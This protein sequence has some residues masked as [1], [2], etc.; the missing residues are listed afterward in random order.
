MDALTIRADGTFLLEGQFLG[1]QPRKSSPYGYL[2][3]TTSGCDRTLKLAKS[4]RLMLFRELTPGDWVRVLGTQKIDSKTGTLEWKAREVLKLSPGSQRLA[5]ETL[6]PS[7]DSQTPDPQTPDSQILFPGNISTASTSNPKKSP[8]AKVL[9]CQK[10][11]CR[12]RGSGAICQAFAHTLEQLDQTD[13]VTLKSTG[14][15]DRCKAGPNV[16]ILPDKARYTHVTPAMVP[17]LI[18]HHLSPVPS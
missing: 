8:Q 14:C 5:P 7:P 6:P 4:L 3:V 1:F 17:E 15:M 16:V 13:Q 9:I 2:R 18:Q 10:S 11:S 12:K